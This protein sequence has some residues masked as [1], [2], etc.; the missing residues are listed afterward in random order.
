MKEINYIEEFKNYEVK[1]TEEER[2]E[3]YFAGE[4][5][6]PYSFSNRRV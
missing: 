1:M 6:D 2:M 5:V 4:R 3:K